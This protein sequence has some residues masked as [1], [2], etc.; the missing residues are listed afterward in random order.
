MYRFVNVS[1]YNFIFHGSVRRNHEDSGKGCKELCCT[2]M[3]GNE[4][5][6]ERKNVSEE[7]YEKEK[8]ERYEKRTSC[9]VP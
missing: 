3:P 1:A 9:C 4:K 5:T 6:K 2:G 7:R 8:G